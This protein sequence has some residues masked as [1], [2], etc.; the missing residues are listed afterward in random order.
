[1]PST[2]IPKGKNAIKLQQIHS[3][4]FRE[5]QRKVSWNE[6]LTEVFRRIAELEP[7]RIKIEELQLEVKQKNEE[8]SNLKD[9]HNHYLQDALNK[10]LERPQTPTL[11]QA[12]P[13]MNTQIASHPSTLPPPP[14]PIQPSLSPKPKPK[15]ISD[16]SIVGNLTKEMK[17]FFIPQKNGDLMNPSEILKLSKPNHINSEIKHIPNKSEEIIDAEPIEELQP[18]IEEKKVK[19]KKKKKKKRKRRFKR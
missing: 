11:V 4:L 12:N 15:Y 17:A 3:Y 5:N 2:I 8:I 9:Q 1:M 16:G 19:K 13:I 10:S 6:V 18:I 14:Q 7:L